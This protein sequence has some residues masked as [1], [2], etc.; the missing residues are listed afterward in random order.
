MLAIVCEHPEGNPIC[1]ARVTG[2]ISVVVRF[3]AVYIAAKAA[4]SWLP[5]ASK[6]TVLKFSYHTTPLGCHVWPLSSLTYSH[7]SSSSRAG[8]VPGRY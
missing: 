7:N 8:G 4:R 2:S 3:P 1:Q 6:S 5:C